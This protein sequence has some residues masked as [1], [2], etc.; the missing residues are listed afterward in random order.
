MAHFCHRPN[1]HTGRDPDGRVVLP[2]SR[3]VAQSGSNVFF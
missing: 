1:F 3:T 2:A